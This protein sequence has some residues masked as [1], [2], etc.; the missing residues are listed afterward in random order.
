M[1]NSGMCNWH[2]RL[3]AGSVLGGRLENMTKEYPFLRIVLKLLF[4]H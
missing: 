1:S 4:P 2:R 3:R